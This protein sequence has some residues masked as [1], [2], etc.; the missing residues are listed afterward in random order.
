MTKALYIQHNFHN[1]CRCI[2]TC[3]PLSS[4]QD[5]DSLWHNVQKATYMAVNHKV[6]TENLQ[7]EDMMLDANWSTQSALLTCRFGE[8]HRFGKPILAVHFNSWSKRTIQLAPLL[9]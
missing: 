1:G 3:N 8:I 5:A 7:A 4:K 9:K 2:L 6:L